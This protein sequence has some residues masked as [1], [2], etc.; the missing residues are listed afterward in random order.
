MT[1]SLNKSDEATMHHHQVLVR[2]LTAAEHTI[3]SLSRT[4]TTSTVPNNA[5]EIQI[6]QHKLDTIMS[7]FTKHFTRCRWYRD[8]SGNTANGNYSIFSLIQTLLVAV[9]KSTQTIKVCSD[10][11]LDVFSTTAR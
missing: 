8:G 5:Q 7:N 4:T 6:R 10:K 3:S 2:W 1:G 11:I 9:S